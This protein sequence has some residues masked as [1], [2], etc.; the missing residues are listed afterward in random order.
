MPR[1]PSLG[2]DAQ[3]QAPDVMLGFA[4]YDLFFVYKPVILSLFRSIDN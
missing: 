4:E 1:R 3:H 2:T